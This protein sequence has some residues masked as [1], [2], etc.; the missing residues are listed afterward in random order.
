MQPIKIFIADDQ[1]LFREGL[2]SLIAGQADMQVVG[3][4]SDGVEAL[5][6]I[7]ELKP[8]LILMDIRM[9]RMDGL[10]ATRRVKAV[11][12][13]AKIVMLT[14]SDLAQELFEAMRHGAVGYLLKNM[15]ARR[16]FEEIRGVMRD[17]VALSPYL[18]GRILKEFTRQREY[19]AVTKGIELGLTDREKQVLGLVVTGLSNKEIGG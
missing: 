7:P 1:A 19:E 2:A 6:K 9:P 17:E 13:D 15:K 12:P 16:L 11:L 3:E 4:A 5:E 10:E 18:A 14:I 8:D